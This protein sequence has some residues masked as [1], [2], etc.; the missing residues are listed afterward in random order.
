MQDRY[1]G[2]ILGE[3]DLRRNNLAKSAAKAKDFHYREVRV[4]S[5]MFEDRGSREEVLNVRL[6]DLLRKRG[7]LASPER[8]RS[9]RTSAGLQ[10]RLPDVTVSHLL[11]IR[12][13]IEGRAASTPG[14]EVT[15]TEDAKR[16]IEEG[17]AS[18][19]IAIVYPREVKEA[20]DEDIENAL[21]A[22]KLRIRILTEEQD[23]EWF[24][25]DTVTLEE[26]LRRTYDSL[27]KESVVDEAVARLGA[28][29][30]NAA[31]VFRDDPNSPDRFRKIIGIR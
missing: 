30:E 19:A 3:G 8:I 6:S 2:Y 18:I 24:V 11:G 25:G 9:K 23:G 17:L 31:Q 20:A 28:V 26:A 16:R 10:R 21:V 27:T 15:L 22:A 13:V 5:Y 7:V 12:V 14:G 29:V 1:P 4:D